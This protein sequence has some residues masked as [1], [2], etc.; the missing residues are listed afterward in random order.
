[1]QQLPAK[2]TVSLP[3]VPLFIFGS[4]GPA[5]FAEQ[6]VTL[7]DSSR[8][9]P[10]L[11]AFFQLAGDAIHAELISLGAKDL[12]VLPD[13]S[14]FRT[15]TSLARYHEAHGYE[16]ATVNG[17]LLATLQAAQIVGLVSKTKAGDVP[18]IFSEHARFAGFCTGDIIAAALSVKLGNVWDLIR[19]GLETIRLV[20]WISLRS[21]QAIQHLDWPFTPYESIPYSYALALNGASTQDALNVI[22]KYNVLVVSITLRYSSELPSDE[23]GRRVRVQIQR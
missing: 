3:H 7:I 18:A 12:A 15:L 16:N 19:Q 4:Q 22:A 23:S 20:F 6:L 9:D 13:V 2:M 21:H 8:D 1:M 10:N 14:K 11:T 5:N 17:I